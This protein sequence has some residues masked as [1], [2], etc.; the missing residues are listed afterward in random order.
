M[1][2]EPKSKGSDRLRH[3]P[4]ARQIAVGEKNA[5]GKLRRGGRKKS[6]SN[7]EESEEFIDAKTTRRIM[8]QAQH[9]R[10]EMDQ[11]KNRTA[12]AKQP[13]A[14]LGAHLLREH[15]D[16]SD[17]SS[18]DD[19]DEQA[20]DLLL[21]PEIGGDGYVDVPDQIAGLSEAE[22]RVMSSFFGTTTQRKTINEL[23]MEKIQE[24]EEA[25][26]ATE[27][28]S[29]RG[30]VSDE[31]PPKV[32]A[33]Y[34]EVGKLLSHYKAG[35]LPKALKIIPSLTNW[36]QVLAVTRPDQWSAMGIYAGT[37]IFASNLN[38]RMAQR[39]YNLILLE[40]VRQDIETNKKL[41]YHLYMALKKAV[42]KPGAFFKGI[43]LPMAL[44]NCNMKEAAI[45]ASVISKVSIPSNH[46][47][48]AILKLAELPYTPSTSLF[49]R[50]L[51]NKKYALPLSVVVNLVNYF[52][53]MN[54][55]KRE[56]P[57]MWHQCLLVFVQRY[58]HDITDEDKERLKLLM[59]LKNHYM[60]T[61]EIRR[62]LFSDQAGRVT[63][64]GTMDL[65]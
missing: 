15:S 39:F 32:V 36:E 19:D 16:E 22:Q 4:L 57:V 54:T 48:V 3:A 35:K 18:D 23:I 1:P 40:R 50:V 65:S 51:L 6:N 29:V 12:N 11:E 55:E 60:I 59:R 13:R 38:E 31:L 30:T 24:K 25:A 27:S 63:K 21:E 20:Q 58:K 41:N 46:S 10:E 34:T 7:A 47:A 64:E 37:R 44:D 2:K 9:Q 5:E 49:L 8:Q 33:C 17:A 43:V 62:E 14:G 52:C 61:A 53:A 28:G 45:L 42:Y 26:N 56:L